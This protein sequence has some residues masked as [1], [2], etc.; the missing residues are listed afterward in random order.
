MAVAAVVAAAAVIRTRFEAKL[1]KS[2]K[3]IGAPKFW[4]PEFLSDQFPGW[5]C[6]FLPH[7]GAGGEE[8]DLLIVL[9]RDDSGAT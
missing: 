4:G 5:I 2:G 6:Y 3:R 9:V 1:D 7:A 8:N